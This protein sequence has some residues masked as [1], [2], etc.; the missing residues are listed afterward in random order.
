MSWQ[1]KEIG[2]LWIIK[3]PSFNIIRN[4]KSDHKHFVFLGCID[5]IGL[6]YAIIIMDPHTQ[7]CV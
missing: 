2:A 7:M 5:T 1:L 6:I 4:N 3:G